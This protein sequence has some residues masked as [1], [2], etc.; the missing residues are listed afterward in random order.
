MAYGDPLYQL[1]DL[2]TRVK[3]LE[4]QSKGSTAVAQPAAPLTVATSTGQ[5]IAG[6]G[7]SQDAQSR[8]ITAAIQ[9]AFASTESVEDSI[10]ASVGLT[11]TGGVPLTLRDT[12]LRP[13]P[14]SGDSFRLEAGGLINNN[15]LTAGSLRFGF[16]FG[17]SATVF[18]T[19]A[20]SFVLAGNDFIGWFLQLL[21]TVDT[22]GST[23]RFAI[24]VRIADTVSGGG[25][26]MAV[27]ED[28]LTDGSIIPCSTVTPHAVLTVTPSFASA[29]LTMSM[30]TYV[31]ERLGSRLG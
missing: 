8:A 16:T 28:Y 13:D 19:P 2:Q 11:F 25:G 17:G 30:D 27:N 3:A 23:G 9:S 15:T 21:V 20:G 5:S 31:F 18:L 7:I 14:A 24:N 22:A 10:N 6:T 26:P 4:Q 12:P 1:N 29:N